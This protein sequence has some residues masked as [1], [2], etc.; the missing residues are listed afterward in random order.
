MMK[1]FHASLIFIVLCSCGKTDQHASMHD[2]VTSSQDK[3][4][5][6]GIPIDSLA[7]H[8]ELVAEMRQR[9]NHLLADSL[10][11]LF[12]KTNCTYA[13]YTITSTW[14]F[15]IE[16]KRK[17][18]TMD[19]DEEGGGTS[20]EYFYENND[21]AGGIETSGYED[22]FKQVCFSLK[23]SF[24]GSVKEEDIFSDTI[25]NMTRDEIFNIAEENQKQFEALMDR[26]RELGSEEIANGDTIILESVNPE[27]F[28]E[29]QP[30][31]EKYSVSSPLF[32]RLVQQK[33]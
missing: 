21:M 23:D 28:N 22:G 33:N 31:S 2:S 15:D 25:Y 10:N 24:K 9:F 27:P 4:G 6:S 30:T 14:F 13:Q 1:Q 3:S 16:L 17:C 12:I 7:I 18:Y 20:S 11:Y 5:S 32:K 26:L 29:Y 8:N 19:V